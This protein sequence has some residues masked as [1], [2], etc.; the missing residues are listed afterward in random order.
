MRRSKCARKGTQLSL[1]AW[2]SINRLFAS[3][4]T[5]ST[6]RVY[7][8]APPS[9][10]QQA[11]LALWTS[12]KDATDPALLQSYLDRFPNGVF[13]GAARIML[14]KLHREA[15]LRD[16]EEKRDAAEKAKIESERKAELA[17]QADELKLA[18]SSQHRHRRPCRAW[19]PSERKEQG[20][21]I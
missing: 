17:R 12:V 10:E 3:C 18:I 19:G 5:V 11:E 15:T 9:S 20:Y 14:E 6:R 2:G 7:F 1:K 8:G 21:L 16:S 13:V 4:S